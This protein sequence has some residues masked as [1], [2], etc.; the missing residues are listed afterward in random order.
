VCSINTG[1]NEHANQHTPINKP[2]STTT[3][4]ISRKITE[5]KRMHPPLHSHG[6]FAALPRRLADVAV[7]PFERQPYQF[8]FELAHL[9]G[10][11]HGS[12]FN[13]RCFHNIFSTHQF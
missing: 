3:A 9:L 7:R 13:P 12:I 5:A 8:G 11:F 6:R 2:P 10:K 4:K 1:R